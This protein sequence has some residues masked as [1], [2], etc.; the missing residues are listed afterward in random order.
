VLE[1]PEAET[2]E[3]LLMYLSRIRIVNFRNFLNLD[4][5]LAGNVVVVGETVSAR[6]TSYTRYSS[7]LIQPFAKILGENSGAG[8]RFRRRNHEGEGG[9]QDYKKMLKA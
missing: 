7:F 4:I 8:K 6:A 3:R 2:L 5:E 1:K 9:L